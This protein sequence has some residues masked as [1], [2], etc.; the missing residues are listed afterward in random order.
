MF[1]PYGDYQ[2]VCRKYRNESKTIPKMVLSFQIWLC[3]VQKYERNF[4]LR[5][6]EGAEYHYLSQYYKTLQ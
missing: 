5:L 2:A 3:S 6:C 1:R 4:D